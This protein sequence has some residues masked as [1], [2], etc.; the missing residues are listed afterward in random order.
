M[1]S[2]NVSA[3]PQMVFNYTFPTLEPAWD[4]LSLCKL[5]FHKVLVECMIISVIGSFG[6]VEN[7]TF[8]LRLQKITFRKRKKVCL[9]VVPYLSRQLA[10]TT[11]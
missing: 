2:P 5:P 1:I 8:F 4:F 7:S 10:S 6:V 9:T 11:L 3:G